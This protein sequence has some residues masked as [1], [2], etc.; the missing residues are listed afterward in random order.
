MLERCGG[1]AIAPM[2]RISRKT[3]KL[4]DGLALVLLGTAIIVSLGGLANGIWNGVSER[5][6]KG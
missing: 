6:A 5:I 4:L 2:M 3:R 1:H